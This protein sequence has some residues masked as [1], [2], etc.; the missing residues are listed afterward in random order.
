MSSVNHAEDLGPITF[1]PIGKRLI[2]AD[3]SGKSY[4]ISTTD[5]SNKLLAA[6]L[7]WVSSVAASQQHI[8]VASGKK[9]LSLARSD[10]HRE[11]PPSGL[12]SLTGGH[13]VGIAVDASDSS[14]FADY[15]QELV[16]GPIPLN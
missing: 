1:D 5:G 16:Q 3:H 9:V 10:N 11:N 8:L 7:G 6:D 14:W 13:I 12:Q 2:A 4:A 15:D